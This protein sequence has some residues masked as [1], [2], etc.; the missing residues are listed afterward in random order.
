MLPGDA[1]PPVL[2]V[3]APTFYVDPMDIL[4]NHTVD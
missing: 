2:Y 4:P 1:V 3:R